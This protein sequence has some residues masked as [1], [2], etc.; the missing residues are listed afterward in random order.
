MAITVKDNSFYLETENT[1]YIFCIEDGF[2]VHLYYGERIGCVNIDYLIDRQIYSFFPQKKDDVLQS[3]AITLEYSGFNTGDYRTCAIKT[4]RA[5]GVGCRLFYSGYEIVSGAA[6]PEGLPHG[7][8]DD[9]KTLV[10][11]LSDE[12]KQISV[13]LFYTVFEKENVIARRAE[14]FND[15]SDLILK[16]AASMLVDFLPCADGY[17][18]IYFSGAV[19]NEFCVE[20][21]RLS[22][23]IKK[24]GSVKGLTSHACNP[25][26]CLCDCSADEEK[27]NVYGFNLLYSG[28]FSC[29]AELDETGKV[30]FVT[31]INPETFEWELR[32]GERFV[33]P[34]AILTYSGVGI[35]GMSRNFHKFL[36]ERVISRKFAFSSRP[37]VIN[38]WEAF[39]VDV[40]ESDV[41]KLADC[42]SETGIDT[43]VLDDGWFRNDNKSGLGEW[44]EDKTKFPSGVAELAEKIRAKG[45]KFGLWIE[46]EMVSEGCRLAL[47]KPE[48]ILNNGNTGYEWRY[49]FSLDFANPEVVDYVYG[50]M[51]D[52]IGRI[53]PDYVKW[54]ANRYLSESGSKSSRIPGETNHRYMLGVYLLLGR[55]TTDYLDVMFESCSGGGGRVDAGMMFYTPQIWISDNTYPFVRNSIQTGASLAYPPSSMSSHFT[56]SGDSPAGFR[57]FVASFAS[58]GYEFDI[59][60]LDKVGTAE[61]ACFSQKY[62]SEEKFVLNGDLYRLAKTPLYQ[63]DMQVLP[64]KSAAL[65]RFLQLGIL[66]GK[67]F[68]YIKL[69]GLD[70]DAYYKNSCNDLVIRGDVLMKAGFFVSDLNCKHSTNNGRQLFFNEYKSVGGGVKILFEKTAK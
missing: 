68:A 26:F 40:N 57:Y 35:G 64:D 38:T 5:D 12:E 48:W 42:A 56:N 11:R 36:R 70:P 22:A 43:I 52:I 18:T 25:F 13:R 7:R 39:G 28:D 8:G 47:E 30:R 60:K 34:Q 63:A 69:R 46:P 67:E 4:E 32:T 10:I 9:C 6:A 2:P 50:I 27:G 61:I 17:D 58:Y 15:G 59:T 33:T 55:L 53:K 20:R 19:G 62:R 44:K 54:D 29:E 16:K 51:K 49:Q 45:L 23:G 3:S 37:I 21:H 24:T 14:I 31:G 41:L 1:S 65:V 66:Q